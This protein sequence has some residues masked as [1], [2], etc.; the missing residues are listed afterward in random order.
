M[1]D[2]TAELVQKHFAEQN[3]L[4][5]CHWVSCVPVVASESLNLW[6][7]ELFWMPIALS[8]DL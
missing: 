8:I 1:E 5:S 4:N 6:E 7:F 2:Q 3:N